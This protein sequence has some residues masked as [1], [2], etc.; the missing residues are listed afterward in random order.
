MVVGMMKCQKVMTVPKIVSRIELTLTARWMRRG[1]HFPSLELQ[2]ERHHGV[3]A[4]LIGAVTALA[5]PVG[6]AG[7]QDSP[8]S[9]EAAQAA[10]TALL[11]AIST[12]LKRSTATPD[13]LG[14]LFS[15][16]GQQQDLQQMYDDPFCTRLPG[17]SW[18]HVEIDNGDLARYRCHV[19][20]AYTAELISVALDENRPDRAFQA[21]QQASMMASVSGGKRSEK[22]RSRT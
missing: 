19:G 15:M 5:P 18:R 22:K 4:W 13:G 9:H 17:L 10:V 21:R 1:D 14:N 6:C 2:H 3:R 11:P 7:S 12:S 20:H 16:M 8:D